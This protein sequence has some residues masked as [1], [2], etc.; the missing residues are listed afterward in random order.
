MSEFSVTFQGVRS[1]LD[2]NSAAAGHLSN[3][4]CSVRSIRS[5][6]TFEIRQRSQIDAQLNALAKE[7]EEHNTSL[8]RLIATGNNVCDLYQRSE[9]NLLG[10]LTVGTTAWVQP[11]RGYISDSGTSQSILEDLLDW[12]LQMLPTLI[13]GAVQPINGLDFDFAKI[14]DKLMDKLD[15]AGGGVLGDITDYFGSFSEFFAGDMSGLSGFAD[16]ANLADNSVG[17]WSDLYDLYKDLGATGNLFTEEMAKRVQGIGLIGSVLGTVGAFMDMMDTTGKSF[18]ERMEDTTDLGISGTKTGISA[19]KLIGGI[20][21]FPAHIYTSIAE[22]GFNFIAQI[23]ESINIYNA[24]GW[25]MMGD[26]GELLIDTSCEGLYS[27]G[28]ALTLGGLGWVLNKITGNEDGDYGEMLSDTLKSGAYDFAEWLVDT[29]Q[30]IG[31]VT[32]DIA[33][34]VKATAED[35]WNGLVSGWNYVFG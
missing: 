7:L 19:L 3:A 10:C 31:E 21:T 23:G 16:W 12:S 17:L 20:G 25:D 26:T 29:G 13:P 11:N 14:L 22:A 4:V 5:R 30:T 2:K 8:H 32:S 18:E 34:T 33:D 27:L 1:A 24:D 15:I 6:L 28:N 35:V 9:N